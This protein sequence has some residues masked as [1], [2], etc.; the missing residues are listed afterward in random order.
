[1]PISVAT[2]PAP[3]CGAGLVKKRHFRGILEPKCGKNRG[4]PEILGKAVFCIF[5]REWVKNLAL[6]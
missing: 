1:M 2:R 5:E 3:L 4:M 6:I